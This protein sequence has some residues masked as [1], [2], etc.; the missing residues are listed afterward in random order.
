M[1]KRK[2]SLQQKRRIASQHKRRQEHPTTATEESLGPPREGLV[3]KRYG[4]QADV[5]P[6]GATDETPFRCHIRA[7]IT[8]LVTGDRVTWREGEGTGIV[9]SVFPRHSLMARPDNNQTYPGS[10]FLRLRVARDL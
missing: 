1:G 9:E 7:N 3:V 5:L 8:D 4:K 10:D 6:D 2:L